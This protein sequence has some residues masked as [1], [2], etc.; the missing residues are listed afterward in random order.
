MKKLRLELDDLTVESFATDGL[1]PEVGTVRAHE[2][3]LRCS[4]GCDTGANTCDGGS[5]CDGG[6]SCV[7]SCSD[8]G[9]NN[10]GYTAGVSCGQL[11]CVYT[12]TSCNP[13]G[14]GSC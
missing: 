12:C 9:T 1:T 7:V 11:S 3:L 13:Y 4:E 6:D 10:C 8:C 2:T 14:C 5:T